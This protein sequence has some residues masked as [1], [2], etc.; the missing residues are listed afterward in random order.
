M[1]FRRFLLFIVPCVV[2]ICKMELSLFTSSSRQTVDVETAFWVL[3]CLIVMAVILSW[4]GGQGF[5][6]VSNVHKVRHR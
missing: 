2:A 3:G 4:P 5:P 1:T 6:Q